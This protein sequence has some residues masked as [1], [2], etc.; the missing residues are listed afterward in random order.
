[1]SARAQWQPITEAAQIQNLRAAAAAD[2]HDPICP[3][4]LGIKAGVITAYAS[5][6]AV[7]FLDMWSHSQLMTARD[8]LTL[9]REMETKAREIGFPA[10]CVPCAAHSPFR[11]L[12]RRMGYN[13]VMESGFFIKPLKGGQ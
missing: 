9:W 8:S 3:T 2:D 13:F 11:P 1:M 6:G 10:L 7:G 5:L 12:M 4:H